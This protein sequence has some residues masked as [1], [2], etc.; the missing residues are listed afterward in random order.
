MLFLTVGISGNRYLRGI[1]MLSGWRCWCGLTHPSQHLMCSRCRRESPHAPQYR[2]GTA[3]SLPS[4]SALVIGLSDIPPSRNPFDALGGAFLDEDQTSTPQPPP[5]PTPHPQPSTAPVPA[6]APAPVPNPA[7]V[8]PIVD[9][10]PATAPAPSPCPTCN[11]VKCKCRKKCPSCG[12]VRS[13][14]HHTRTTIRAHRRTYTCTAPQMKVL[15]ST[16]APRILHTAVASS[17]TPTLKRRL[18]KQGAGGYG[19]ATKVLSIRC[20]KPCYDLGVKAADSA[21]VKH[22]GRLEFEPTAKRFKTNE[23]TTP[24]KTSG[25]NKL[26]RV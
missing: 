1:M 18:S 9:L 12:Q 22:P 24:L 5:Q 16:L 21:V 2:V 13:R 3:E 25:G 19:N 8:P 10:A 7:S 17:G 4:L 20:C 15:D 14:L 26:V 23:A 11:K 6:S